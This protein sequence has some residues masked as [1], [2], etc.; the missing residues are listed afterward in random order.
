MQRLFDPLRI[1]RLSS[2][3][4]ESYVRLGVDLNRFWN[5]S[6]LNV[7]SSATSVFMDF[8]VT[9]ASQVIC[10]CPRSH[11]LLLGEA[12]IPETRLETPVAQV[13]S[14]AAS[15]LVNTTRVVIAIQF[16]ACVVGM[17][18]PSG[19]PTVAGLQQPNLA[20]TLKDSL[21]W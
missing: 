9:D 18:Q 13:S 21:N 6:E 16:V 19:D 20:A 11:F 4:L 7:M 17:S 3:D 2:D 12:F 10:R 8:Q 15:L 5:V 14:P 1:P